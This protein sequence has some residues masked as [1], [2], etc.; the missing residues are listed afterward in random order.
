MNGN[1]TDAETWLDIIDHM[2]I[3][4][5]LIAVAGV[6]SWFAARNHKSIKKVQDQVVNGHKT[7]MREDLDKLGENIISISKDIRQ[8]M[9]FIKTELSD[10]RSEINI[11][12][13]ERLG[14]D[15][16]FESYRKSVG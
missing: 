2:W 7:P 13:K 11:E 8:D 10:I 15:D 3:G 9:H 1:W 4:F 16:R 12:R 14:L 5:V 6:P